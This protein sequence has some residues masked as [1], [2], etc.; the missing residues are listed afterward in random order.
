MK[1]DIYERKYVELKGENTR[2]PVIVRCFFFP[3]NHL[4]SLLFIQFYPNFSE[5]DYKDR[6][7]PTAF[8]WPKKE[9]KVKK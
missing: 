6:K 5:L 2:C 9:M 1:I 7:F 8:L 3:T 4:L